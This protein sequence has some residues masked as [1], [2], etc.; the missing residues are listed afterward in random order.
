MDKILRMGRPT[1]EVKG[2][3]GLLEFRPAV[4]WVESFPN[5]REGSDLLDRNGQILAVV[6]E[7]NGTMRLPRDFPTDVQR[8]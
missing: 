3:I 7:M 1:T 5:G 2:S 8:Q 6:L 4:M